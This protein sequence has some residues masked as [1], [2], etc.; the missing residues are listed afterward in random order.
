LTDKSPIGKNSIEGV[1]V[2]STYI[3][4]DTRVYLD[5]RG[6][7]L[8]VWEQNHI[9]TLDPRAYYRNGQ[10]VWLSLLPEN[11]LILPMD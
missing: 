1:V 2:T 4:S 8:K 9:S 5:V 10:N 11:T 3:G 6:L 7:R